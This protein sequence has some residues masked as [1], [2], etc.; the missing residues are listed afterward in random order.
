[1][2]FFAKNRW[3]LTACL[4]AA[5]CFSAC[6]KPL[7]PVPKPPVSEPK[8]NDRLSRAIYAE[9]WQLD[10]HFARSEAESAPLRDLLTGLLAFNAEGVPTAAMALNWQSDDGKTW[11][12]ALD[13]NAFWS[14]GEKVSADDFVASWQRLASPANASPLAHYLRYMQVVNAAE[15]LKGEKLPSELGVAALGANLLQ[16]QLTETNYQLPQMLAHIALLPTFRGEVP[17]VANFVSNGAYRLEKYEEKQLT[18]NAQKADTAFQQVNFARLSEIQNVDRFDVIENPL[19]SYSRDI[20]RFPRLCHYFYEFN[21]TD[22][23]LAKKP[24]RQA[25]RAMLSPVEISQG[26]GIPSY[27]AVPPTLLNIA[28]RPLAQP[29]SEQFAS[30]RLMELRLSYDIQGEHPQIAERI[31]RSLGQSELFRIT[32]QPMSWD[33]LLN[34]REKRE[35]QL[36]RSGW[37]SDYPDAV[38]FLRPFHSASPDNKSGYANPAVDDALEKLAQPMEPKAREQLILTVMHILEDDVA[39]LPLFQYQRRVS[40]DPSLRGFD[41]QNSSAVIY[42]KDLYRQSRTDNEPT[43]RTATSG[44]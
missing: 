29:T 41:L 10:P 22:P 9:S 40:L 39:L 18:L 21:F 38:A 14:N 17:N 16:I 32:P 34:G 13:E 27:F 24:V 4:L 30:G 33:E 5:F 15:I 6:D 20:Q 42:S 25:I 11:L 28:N 8:T 44:N 19:R 23:L 26:Q 1:M 37:C 7:P 43:D 31:I 2:V 35:F 12:F 3:K 36:S